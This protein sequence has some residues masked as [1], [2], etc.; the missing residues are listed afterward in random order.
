MK[1]AASAIL[2]FAMAVPAFASDACAHRG[3]VESAPE[4][5]L[6]AL[7]RAVEKGAKQIEFDLAL[8]SDKR[9]V[10]MH[11]YTVDRTTNGAGKVSDLTFDTVRA[12]DAGSW[13]DANFKGEQVPTLEEALSVI[14]ETVLCNVHLKGGPELAQV[15]AKEIRRLGRIDQCFLACTTDQ[16]EAARNVV[17]D[18]QTCNMSRQTGDRA[19]Y[20]AKTI[21]LKCEFI[22]LHQ[23]DGYENLKEEVE[24]LHAGGVTVNWF[25]ANDVELMRVLI[26]AK[27]DYILTDKLSLCLEEVATPK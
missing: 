14:P 20:I 5:T 10:L 2:V 25:G 3:D 6:A 4:N 23:R 26:A 1:I 9:I 19:A 16:I 27:V 7:R 21:E 18:I 8:T 17:P 15:A 24:Q 22:Q 11:D 12:L 13:F